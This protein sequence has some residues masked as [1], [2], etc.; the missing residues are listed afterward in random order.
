MPAGRRLAT[1]GIPVGIVSIVIMLVVPLPAVLLDVL[2]AAN[3]AVSVLILLVA[4]QVQRPLDFAVFPS[5]ILVGT[6]FRLSLNVSQRRRRAAP[7]AVHEL[8]AGR[9]ARER[10]RRPAARLRQPHR[11][12][13][14]DRR[15]R[16][17]RPLDRPQGVLSANST[18]SVR[19]T[20][21]YSAR[22]FG[23]CAFSPASAGASRGAC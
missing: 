6:L 12:A 5:L 10:R 14:H 3:I 4:M 2:I 13:D 8:L 1:V 9:A 20:V 23:R 18:A 11:P 17:R 15:L 7:A 22:C 16:L 19:G 21:S